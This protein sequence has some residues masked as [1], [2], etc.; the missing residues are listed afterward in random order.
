MKPDWDKVAKEFS[1][2]DSV[3][4][5]DVDCTTEQTLC[6]KHGV[7][8][9]PTIKTFYPGQSTGVDFQG[10]R[11]LNGLRAHAQSLVPLS[12]RVPLKY[13]VALAVAA[14]VVVYIGGQ[15]ARLW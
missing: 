4:I 11:N 6:E 3:L 15:V 13:R 1:S 8:G 2:S 10:G 7:S 5:A 12:E 9:Y 14:L